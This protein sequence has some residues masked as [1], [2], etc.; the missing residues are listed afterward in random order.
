MTAQLLNRAGQ[1]L[2]LV[3]GADKDQALDQLARRD[4]QI[5]ATLITTASTTLVTDRPVAAFS[6]D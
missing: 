5:P 3:T 4:A 2:F 1:R 6:P